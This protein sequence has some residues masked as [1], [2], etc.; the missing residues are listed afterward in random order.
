[1]CRGEMRSSLVVLKLG[2]LRLRLSRGLDAR[3]CRL[4][5]CRSVMPWW[6]RGSYATTVSFA[7]TDLADSITSNESIA[8]ETQQNSLPC[9]RA[10]P[11]LPLAAEFLF[12]PPPDSPGNPSTRPNFVAR[13]KISIDRISSHRP[14]L[15]LRPKSCRRKRRIWNSGFTP[16]S[17]NLS[18]T[19]PCSLPRPSRVPRVLSEFLPFHCRHHHLRICGIGFIISEGQGRRQSL[20]PL[21]LNRSPAEHA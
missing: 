18:A 2:I 21:V 10:I 16:R 20:L 17:Q 11:L 14:R 6:R 1:M 12:L 3:G 13:W 7:P 15:P 9:P 8:Y 5:R 4:L 19:H